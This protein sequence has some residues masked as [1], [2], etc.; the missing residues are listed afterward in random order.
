MKLVLSK[1]IFLGRYVGVV[2]LSEESL[3]PDM[4]SLCS[5][6]VI[7]MSRDPCSGVLGYGHDMNINRGILKSVGSVPSEP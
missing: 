4:N 6:R 3:Y 5:E 1:Y 7:N 2:A